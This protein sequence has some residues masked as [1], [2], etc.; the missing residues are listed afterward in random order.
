MPCLGIG[1]SEAEVEEAIED[2]LGDAV[3]E[4]QV[5]PELRTRFLRSLDLVRVSEASY[6]DF[7]R[8]WI[9]GGNSLG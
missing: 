7:V 3:V 2:L 8:K 1:V 4:G 6:R 5:E 9:L